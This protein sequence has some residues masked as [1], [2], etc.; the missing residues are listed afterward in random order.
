M[1]RFTFA[2]FS[3][4]VRK[5]HRGESLVVMNFWTLTMGALLLCVVGGRELL[6]APWAE[7]PTGAWLSLLWLGVM[8][9]GLTFYLAKVAST[10]LPSSKVMSYTYLTPVFVA[11]EQAA[12]GGG[13]PAP[14]MGVALVVTI[15]ATLALQ[16]L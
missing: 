8:N 1:S 12:L 10:K 3:P 15:L 13:W 2:F 16:R 7:L 4:L 14:M 6:S 9:T 5:F 11:L